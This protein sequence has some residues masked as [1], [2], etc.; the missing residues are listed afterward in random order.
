MMLPVNLLYL[1]AF[2][3]I[4]LIDFLSFLPSLGFLGYVICRL[5]VALSWLQFLAYVILMINAIAFLFA[6]V[7]I[8]STVSF[9][10]TQSFGLARIFDNFL[11]IGR[12]PLDIFQGFWKIF[13]VYFLPLVLIAQLPSQ[14]LLKTLSPAFA[15]FAVG[16][17]A[18][19]L[20]L[21][22][23]FWKVGLKNYLSAS[24]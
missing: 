10:T 11:K 19:F 2:E 5:D 20:I 16:V 15:L 9:W 22:L 12:Y 1:V 8:I 18:A 3:G 6:V 17:T 21:A 13:F 23:G 24:T 14:A 7:L 4:D